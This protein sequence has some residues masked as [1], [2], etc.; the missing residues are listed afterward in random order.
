[1]SSPSSPRA[2]ALAEDEGWGTNNVS[3]SP[4]SQQ[5]WPVLP[6]A[7]STTPFNKGLWSKEEEALFEEGLVRYGRNNK[8]ISQLV[9]TRSVTQVM[10]KKEYRQK[11]AKKETVKNLPQS[12]HPP[13]P[14]CPA[15]P[16]VHLAGECLQCIA[17]C[18]KLSGHRG[19]H[20]R[21]FSTNVMHVGPNR[22]QN[23]PAYNPNPNYAQTPPAYNPNPNYA[24][25]L[26]THAVPC[27]PPPIHRP[28]PGA[29]P[30]AF[31]AD[32]FHTRDK[33]Y[34]RHCL[35]NATFWSF[36]PKDHFEMPVLPGWQILGSAK[37]T[38]I[39]FTYRVALPLQLSEL[40]PPQF[41]AT[42]DCI[43][44]TPY[45]SVNIFDNENG[46]FTVLYEDGHQRREATVPSEKLEHYDIMMGKE[47]TVHTLKTALEISDIIKL[48]SK[49]NDLDSPLVGT[50][51]TL[52][53]NIQENESSMNWE[54]NEKE[55]FDFESY[56]TKEMGLV[57]PHL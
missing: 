41:C 5:H 18:G 6:Q 45:T 44:T 3:S 23:P 24:H 15:E 12:I 35:R 27:D 22:A 38:G 29:F 4:P 7:A 26:F 21:S 16:G 47:I 30:V 8:R 34:L 40:L 53:E 25:S 39:T 10:A 51:K 2:S 28:L 50:F 20:K 33:T 48:A 9:G 56:V 36:P 17:G 54:E 14:L 11:K 37:S 32:P 55:S 57:T 1:M 43:K 42:N 19:L 52:L 13:A 31:E 46:T 49:G